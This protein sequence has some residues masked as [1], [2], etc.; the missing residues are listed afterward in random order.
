MPKCCFDVVP[1]KLSDVLGCRAFEDA[2]G[3]L[4]TLKPKY[5]KSLDEALKII[6]DNDVRE[7]YN[8]VIRD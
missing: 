7:S 6:D 2:N 5:P 3:N 1:A 4:M 8:V